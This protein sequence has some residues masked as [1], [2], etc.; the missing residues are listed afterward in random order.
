[1]LPLAGDVTLVRMDAQDEAPDLTF[2]GNTAL[3]CGKLAV[4][5]SFRHPERRRQ[6]NAFRAALSRAGLATTYLRRTYFEGGSDTLFDRVRAL[7]YAA[8]GWNKDRN[9]ALELCEIVG[10]RVLPLALIDE[11]FFH[12]DTA[13]CP[14]GSGH[15]LAYLP[16]FAPD[17]Q[18]RLR[19]AVEP[20]FLIEID[21]E[22]ALAL[23]CNAVEIEDALVLH[24]ASRRLRGQL[25]ELGYRVFCTEL[26]EF[27]SLGRGAKKL[28]LRL[29]DG[30]GDGHL[31]HFHPS[32]TQRVAR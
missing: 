15:V 12:L 8:T 22:D 4:L 5:S 14:L 9:E 11:R 24:A 26:D 16:A 13:L 10:C 1:M 17:A 23:A 30:P 6:Q 20:E 25:K 21:I 18:T 19:R 29:D 31:H 28:T 32:I 27:V 7:C 3:I 2:T